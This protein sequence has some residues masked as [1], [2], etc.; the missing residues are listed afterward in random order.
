[1][2]RSTSYPG[3]KTILK[4]KQHSK[5]R[6]EH[7]RYNKTDLFFLLT[8]REQVSVQAQDRPQP[9]QPSLVFQTPHTEQ[10]PCGTD[11]Q[12]AEHLLQSCPHYE[13]LRKGIWPDHT[14]ITRKLF[15]SLG[16]FRCTAIFIEETGVSIRR[17]R[18]S[19]VDNDPSVAFHA[20]GP[21]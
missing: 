9:P 16:A 21:R 7:P 18:R 6:L 17:A 12:T 11:S 3:M 8:R 5:W 19:L 10:C 15:G 14:P 20:A 1:M 4:T 2:D 13:L